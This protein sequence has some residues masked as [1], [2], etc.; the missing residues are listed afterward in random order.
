MNNQNQKSMGYFPC[1]SALVPFFYRHIFTG[2]CVKLDSD[3]SSVYLR[4]K[5]LWDDFHP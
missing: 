3:V 5:N 2:E 1:F 4:T